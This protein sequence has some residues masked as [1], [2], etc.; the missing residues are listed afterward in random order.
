MCGFSSQSTLMHLLF[1]LRV[2]FLT[3]HPKQGYECD[4]ACRHCSCDMKD[5]EDELTLKP[6]AM[7]EWALAPHRKRESSSKAS[8]FE[9]PDLGCYSTFFKENAESSKTVN[10][11]THPNESWGKLRVYPVC[12]I[13]RKEVL[14]PLV[15]PLERVVFSQVTLSCV[16]GIR[17]R[18]Q[19]LCKFIR[20][21]FMRPVHTKGGKVMPCVIFHTLKKDEIGL[22][23]VLFPPHPSMR[24][25]LGTKRV[26][27]HQVP[28]VSSNQ[29]LSQIRKKYHIHTSMIWT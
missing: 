6:D 11:F 28:H 13:V 7:E 4:Q 27:T 21:N 26:Q 18:R 17:A 5:V 23:V 16:A 29:Q 1:T 12:M 9:Y 22:G 25:A 10:W 15:T 19:N 3:T 8:K 14:G 24:F 20:V 2:L